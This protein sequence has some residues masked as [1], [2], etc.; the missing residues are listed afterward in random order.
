MHPITP[1]APAIDLS[2]NCFSPEATAQMERLM[3]DF[4]RMYNERK[5]A[6]NEVARAHHEA[7]LLLSRAAEFRDDDTGVHIVRIGYLAWALALLLGQPAAWAL[8]LRQAA[9]MHD[10]GKIGMP[11]DVLKKP[12]ALTPQDR[13]VMNRHP[14]I[15]AEILGRSRIPLF[16]LAAETALTHHERWDGQGYPEGLSGN[17]IP[18]A[19]RIVAV[20]DFFDA[21]TMDRCYRPAFSHERALH[22]LR[23]ERAK[24]FDPQIVDTFLAHADAIIALRNRINDGQLGLA[25]LSGSDDPTAWHA[26][27][28]PPSSAQADIS[29][30]VSAPP[31]PPPSTPAPT[32]DTPGAC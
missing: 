19:G 21:L 11:D 7:L 32:P 13:V 8:L 14:A 26:G 10:V 18:L 12:G 16:Q 17:A 5:D 1:P 15:G 25:E 4:G 9:P 20:V 30:L 6:L 29:A 27:G 24:A 22:M 2:S 28:A 3:A 23:A 31:A